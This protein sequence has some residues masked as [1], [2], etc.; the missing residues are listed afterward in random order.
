MK[1]LLNKRF[2]LPSF[3]SLIVIFL[4]VVIS[5]NGNRI[6]NSVVNNSIWGNSVSSSYFY[7]EDSTYILKGDKCIKNEY[8]NQLLVGD[9][10]LDGIFD[11][12]DSTYVQLYINNKLS[13]DESAKTV[14]DVNKDGVVDITDY[15]MIQKALSSSSI[16][17]GSP[18]SVN[19]TS[20]YNIGK[21]KVCLN[22]Y[23]KNNG[24]CLK[25]I[26]VNAIKVDFIYGDINSD[27]K[28]DEADTNILS[29]Y[30][31]GSYNLND[32]Q[33]RIADIN[34]DG[35]VDITDLNLINSTIN[36]NDKNSIS[37][38]LSTSSNLNSVVINSKVDVSA[39]FNVTS[40][41]KYYY[42]W[43]DIKKTDNVVETECKAIPNNKLD[44][45]S[46]NATD[47]NEY[48]L[49]KVY[50]DSKCNN[51]INLY[52]TEEI[53][54]IEEVSS[55]N[56]DYKLVS[57]LLTTNIVNKD[58][59]LKFY[60]KF[61]VEGSKD[62]YYKWDVYKNSK[63]SNNSKCIKVI[64]DTTINSSMKVDGKDTYGVFNIY[65]DSSCNNLVNSYETERYNYLADSIGLNTSS[66]RLNVGSTLKLQ[67]II[68]SNINNALEYVKWSSSNTAVATVDSEGV[69][70]GMKKGSA[71]ITATLGNMSSTAVITVVDGGNDTS[72]ECPYITYDKEGE[73]TLFTIN[74][75]STIAKYDIYLSTNNQVGS[76]AKFEAKYLNNTG[77]KTFNNIIDNTYSNQ[78][79]IVVYSSYGT[80][81][82]CY[83]SPLTWKYNTIS[84]IAKCPSFKYTYDYNKGTNSYS[85]QIDGQKVKSGI[86]KLHVKFDLNKDYQYSW[87]TSKKDG[88]YTLFSTYGTYGKNIE[89][90]VTGNL[91]NR[92]GQVVVTDRMGNSITCNTE[93]I[94][95]ISLS[96][97]RIGTTEIYTENGFNSNDKKSVINEMKKM[98][99]D[100]PSYLA[101]TS[102]LLLKTETYLSL[103]GHSC[104]NYRKLSNILAIRESKSTNDG[105][106]CGGTATSTY[107]KG[108]IKHE[109]GHSMDHMNEL[110]TGTSLSNSLY[111]NKT[112]KSYV[113]KYNANKKQCDGTFCLR[114]RDNYTY[115]DSYW[116]FMADIISFDSL[117]FRVN[118]DLLH[119]RKQVLDKYFTNYKKNKTKF[120]QIKESFK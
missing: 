107:Y 104:G 117:N 23:V 5:T 95:S 44:T 116:E 36:E 88:G 7:C 8:S 110:L 49:L 91:Y 57:P 54:I 71:E 72:I 56:L 83:T 39:T 67:P 118:N 69:V 77:K 61:N 102:V 90:G 30:L 60:G 79:K 48:V 105:S 76:W 42:K 28:V 41:R 13:F 47:N 100:N 101:A 11:I 86:S 4:F 103:Y 15:T 2:I 52:K 26:T 85:Y 106:S 37:V 21:D 68:K 17:N 1:K 89:N 20:R 24:K 108:T 78:A 97:D 18:N 65:K 38:D 40:N 63:L 25:K 70:T 43:F 111:S 92:N 9:A 80:S 29:N 75:H 99:N 98:Y 6:Y 16:T 34:Q 12:T 19:D 82:N 33:L 66:S 120:E 62:Y 22:G 27:S 35:I 51:Q 74:T 87:R 14:C 113:D 73:A 114:Y 94:N 59:E 10:N 50:N 45:Y 81:R 96:K 119:L 112:F 3:I 109:L 84:S 115:G 58:T 46:I 31:N 53:K 32:I 93:S 55:I 64:N